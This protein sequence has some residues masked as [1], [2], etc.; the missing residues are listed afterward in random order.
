VTISGFAF[1]P[2]AII[3]APGQAVV[4]TNGDAVAHTVTSADGHWD[5]GN[6]AP[7]GSYRLVLD[8]PGTYA[9]ACAIHPFMHGTVTVQG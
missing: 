6:F 3:T 9:Y 1:A 8:Q 5:S 4:F 2:A 7:G